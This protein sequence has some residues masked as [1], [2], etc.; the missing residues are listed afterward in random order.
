MSFEQVNEVVAALRYVLGT[1]DSNTSPRDYTLEMQNVLRMANQV[2][3]RWGAKSVDVP[4]LWYA[5][6]HSNQ[7]VLEQ[8]IERC[9]GL[10]SSALWKEIENLLLSFRQA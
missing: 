9:C 4:H 10:A 3:Q 2:A 1:G 5:V 8:V 7:Y 6:L